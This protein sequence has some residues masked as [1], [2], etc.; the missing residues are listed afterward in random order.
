M[1]I[2]YLMISINVQRNHGYQLLNFCYYYYRIEKTKRNKQTCNPQ[3][4]LGIVSNFLLCIEH[5]TE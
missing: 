1:K 5:E 2:N 3:M 4:R